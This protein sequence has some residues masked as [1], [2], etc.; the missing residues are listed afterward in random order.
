MRQ[1]DDTQIHCLAPGCAETFQIADLQPHV[2][3]EVLAEYAL[4]QERRQSVVK[5][6]NL[7]NKMMQV[8]Y[9]KVVNQSSFFGT[10]NLIS[11]AAVSSSELDM[12]CPR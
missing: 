7:L 12:S 2:S 11:S 8:F 1:K 9:E 6:N 10:E 3:F 5:R 4:A